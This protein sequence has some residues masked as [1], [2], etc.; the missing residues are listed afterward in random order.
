M[1][2]AV[3]DMSFAKSVEKTLYSTLKTKNSETSNDED[4]KHFRAGAI[5]VLA[6][7]RRRLGSM[8]HHS[9]VP[10]NFSIT[11]LEKRRNQYGHGLFIHF[12][13]Y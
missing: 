10:D 2:L 1:S 13:N 11:S 12:V 7:M 5:L 6:C 4:T 9:S 8:A 3:T